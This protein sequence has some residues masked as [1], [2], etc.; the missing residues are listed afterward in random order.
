MCLSLF[1]LF[2]WWN[3]IFLKSKQPWEGG[4]LD[5]MATAEFPHQLPLCSLRDWRKYAS[6]GN[7]LTAVVFFCKTCCQGTRVQKGS[8]LP[9]DVPKSTRCHPRF[10]I[11]SAVRK[12][13]PIHKICHNFPCNYESRSN[14]F[15]LSAHLPQERGLFYPLVNTLNMQ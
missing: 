4:R 6:T 14:V 11:I 5:A 2:H 1:F 7:E 10:Y 12:T 9:M 3:N 13:H 8:T 15:P